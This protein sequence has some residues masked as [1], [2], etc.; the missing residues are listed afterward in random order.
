[1]PIEKKAT[2]QLDDSSEDIS[3]N[4]S[5]NRTFRD[6]AETH[7]SRR[8][9]LKGSLAAAAT[10]FLAP[11]PVYARGNRGDSGPLIDFRPATIEAAVA[12]EGKTVVISPDYEY[13]TLIPWGTPINP[14]SG[15]RPYLG[16]PDRRP[17]SAEQE[18]LVGIGHDGMWF[19]PINLRWILAW[20]QR[21]GRELPARIRNRLLS[22]RAGI[23]CINHEFG[24]NSHV[25]GKSAPES[26]EDVRLSQA[27]HGVSV[28]GIRENFR[29]KW[30]VMFNPNARRITVNTPVAFSGPAAGSAL[31]ESPAD[32]SKLGTVNNCGS[33]PTPW[34]TYLTC[35]ENFNAYFGSTRE[36]GTF[37]GFDAL[38]DEAYGRYG[39]NAF[40]FGYFWYQFDERFDLSNPQFANESNRFGWI[41]EIDPFDGSKKPIKRTALGRFKHEATAVKELADGRVAV[42]MGDDQR[43]DY[44]YKYESNRPWRRDIA[45]GKSP[46]DD[47]KL[48]VARFDDGGTPNTGRGT[49]EWIELTAADP[50]IQNAGL[51]T[52]EQVLV[53]TRLAADTVGATVMDRPE[54]TTIG[55][56]GQVFWTLTNNNRKDRG[57]G[58][59]SDVNPIFDNSDGHIVVTE[60]SSSTTF[61]WNMYI[62]ARNTRAEDPGADDRDVSYATYS[63]PADGGANVFTDPDAAWADPF[64]RLFIGT[65]GGQPSGL[66][67][68]LLVFDVA[69]G[70]YRRL[71]V[72]VSGDEITGVA[73][74]PDYETLFTN[75]QHPGDGDPTET[76]FPA[77]FDGTTIPRD[78]TIVVRRKNRGQVGS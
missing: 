19:Y 4:L 67:D 44:C 28:V 1:M 12:A 26:L 78:A 41:V 6:V 62:L 8:A 9:V 17:T 24:T 52:Q 47:G 57:D 76:N 43:G 23:L 32:N 16:E 71:M 15:V 77:P 55:T 46:L 54:W 60:D 75:S 48:Y 14:F 31:L 61:E 11:A 64:G 21:R 73:V 40:G 5:G 69:S 22:S 34:G 10:G 51:V 7:L 18:Q 37:G 33:G 29:S 65:D 70:E 56:N 42:Y 74:T 72:G 39:F 27:A 58:A 2:V 63:P 45:Q 3:S 68:Q 20:E 50:R 35:E 66:Q 53:Y 49:G 36:D 25:L 30:Q 38:Q 59:V 13:D